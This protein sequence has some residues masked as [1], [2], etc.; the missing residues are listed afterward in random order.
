MDTVGLAQLFSLLDT[1]ASAE[2]AK[3]LARTVVCVI[4][5][6]YQYYYAHLSRA[7]LTCPL[8]VAYT[9]PRDGFG[10]LGKGGIFCNSA[11]ASYIWFFF[12]LEA[13]LTQLQVASS[14][15]VVPMQSNVRRWF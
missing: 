4:G 15:L 8:G 2:V 3:L 1:R 11:F 12:P 14:S 13:T 9:R 10:W 7:W 6:V 5:Q